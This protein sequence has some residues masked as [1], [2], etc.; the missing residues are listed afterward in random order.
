MGAAALLFV[1][2]GLWFWHI[3]ADSAAI[4]D[5]QKAL[6]GLQFPVE[7]VRDNAGV[8]TLTA[9]TLPD[10]AR[11]LG[12]LH[13]QERYFQM[14]TLRR[15][16]AGELSG[17]A[18]DAAFSIDRRHRVH[19]FRARAQAIFTQ[20]PPGQRRLLDA[21]TEG[22]NAG[23]SALGRKPFEYALLRVEP[24]PWRAEDTLLIIYAMYFELQD[25][26]GWA[27]RRK[28]LAG[29]A[30]GAPL[31]DF[32]YPPGEADDAALDGSILPLPPM[33]QATAASTTGIPSPAPP[34]PNGSN[35]FAVSASKSKSGR[36]IVAND[37]HLPLRVP[38]IWY[39]ARLK[40]HQ[41]TEEGLDLNGVTLPG[42]PLLVAGSNGKIAWGFTDAYIATSDAIK[43]TP[44]PGD[45][46]SYLTPS[47]PLPLSIV[48]EKI[49]AARGGCQDLEVE[50]SIWGPVVARE[51]D[52][53]RIVLR[54][55]AHDVNA[56]DFDGL[57]AFETASTVRQAFDAAHRA[58]LPQQN[59]VVADHEG[60][61]G[62]TIMGQIPKRLGFDQTQTSWANGSR[63]WQGYLSP[64]E[65]PELIDPAD[66]LIWSANNRA[67][68]GQAFSLL[69]DGGYASA[70][71]AKRIRD[72]LKAEDRFGE[73]SLLSIQ[74]DVRAPDLDPWQK[75]LADMLRRRP[76]SFS[77][78]ALSFVEGWDGAA[79]PGSV[80]Y[81]LVR[82][83]EEEAVSLIYGGFGGVIK[84][85]AGPDAGTMTARR[86]HGPSLRLL[87]EQPKHLVPPPFKTWQDLMD[88]LYDRFRKRVQAESGGNLTGFTWGKRNYSAIH[89]P[90]A[91]A[92]P[93]LGFLTD[94]P[95]VPI[96][97]DTLVPRAAA[98][99]YGSSERFVIS[100]GHESEGIFEMPAG[101]AGNPLSPYYLAGHSDWTGG[102]ASAFLPGAPRWR[103]VLTPEP[104][105]G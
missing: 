3:L 43:L 64:D 17:L 11:A 18:G 74:L 79:A 46:R 99:G 54:W 12:F 65:I 77:L 2:S 62:W 105:A 16:G 73:A 27:Q 92:L 31:A 100:P 58:G 9:R 93:L 24:A 50:E 38:N 32:L 41:A 34:P 48:T 97:G 23:L 82:S 61:I 10:L 20:M 39:R 53:S 21:Y 96:P 76:D 26:S 56:I 22:V 86:P 25:G 63:A 71:R 98:P 57:F 36:A 88:A 95:D 91:V 81:R 33:P 59:L 104:N 13:A 102:K 83:F 85:L 30:L 47:G 19:R 55:A 87:S 68:G 103:L 37:M 14:D 69:G 15:S 7:I 51:A 1:L 78:P 67:I 75:L 84:P 29:K 35:A 40:V 66:G 70:S 89:H 80:G 6:S 90:L 45:P 4:L 49:C 28:A 101:Q 8:P 42:V 72:R 60:H 44:A 94:P 5:G 52:G